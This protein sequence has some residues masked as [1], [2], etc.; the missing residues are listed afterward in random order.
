MFATRAADS[1]LVYRRRGAIAATLWHACRKR[2]RDREPFTVE[3]VSNLRHIVSDLE[4]HVRAGSA[5]NRG[6]HPNDRDRLAPA[7]P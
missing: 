5:K 6:P 3:K 7:T 4:K 2:D 1:A